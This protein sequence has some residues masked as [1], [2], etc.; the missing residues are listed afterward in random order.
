MI[1]GC[2]TADVG[3]L[4]VPAGGDFTASIQKGAI[5]AKEIQGQSRQHA[6]LLN[7]MGV[8]QLIVGIN[9][10]DAGMNKMDETGAYWS[11]KLYKEDKEEMTKMLIGVGWKKEF[12]DQSVAFIPLSGWFGDNLITITCHGTRGGVSKSA[13][14]R[15]ALDLLSLKHLTRSSPRLA[16]PKSHY[17]LQSQKF[18]TQPR[19]FP[20]KLERGM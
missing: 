14:Q 9:R 2:V 4:L 17:C 19:S 1:E 20:S 11:E 13:P 7:I 18:M 3:L 10:M 8:K 15:H 6:R 12:V 16:P 5:K